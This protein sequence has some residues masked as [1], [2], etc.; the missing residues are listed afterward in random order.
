MGQEIEAGKRYHLNLGLNQTD[1][2]SLVGARRG[3]INHILSDWRNR[4]LIEYAAGNITILDLPK[5]Q[6]EYEHRTQVN[7]VDW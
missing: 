1:L 2:A 4:G 3:W 7:L 6:Q 5:I